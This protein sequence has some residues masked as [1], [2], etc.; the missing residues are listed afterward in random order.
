MRQRP[1]TGRDR[2]TERTLSSVSHGSVRW[3]RVRQRGVDELRRHHSDDRTGASEEEHAWGAVLE[4]SGD[5]GEEEV[6]RDNDGVLDV[7]RTK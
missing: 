6:D 5:T 3:G 2:E 1:A 4:R 7:A